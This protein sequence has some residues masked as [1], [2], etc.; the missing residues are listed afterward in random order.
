[1]QP[2]DLEIGD[3]FYAVFPEGGETF[4][5]FKNGNEYA[6]IQKDEG[7]LWLKLDK[8]TGTP[9]FEPDD[10]INRLGQLIEAYKDMPDDDEQIE[11]VND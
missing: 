5:I 3:D 11:H 1:M 8:E 7:T 10:E 9:N 4:T 2:F 6:Q